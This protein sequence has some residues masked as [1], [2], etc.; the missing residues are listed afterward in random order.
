MSNLCQF[1]IKLEQ[2]LYP[3]H[4]IGAFEKSNF[5]CVK[6]PQTNLYVFWSLVEAKEIIKF[7]LFLFSKLFVSKA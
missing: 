3:T 1:K 2:H 5:T 4:F 7:I 6:N